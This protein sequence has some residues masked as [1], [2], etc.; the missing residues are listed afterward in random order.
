[1]SDR[2]VHASHPESV[3]PNCELG[4]TW[5]RDPLDGRA[6]LPVLDELAQRRGA[7]HVAAVVRRWLAARHLLHPDDGPPPGQRGPPVAPVR[8]QASS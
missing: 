3:R 7:A 5:R 4:P 8:S 1:M 2:N 6:L